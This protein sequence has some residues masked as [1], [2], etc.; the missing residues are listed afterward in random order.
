M[1]VSEERAALLDKL[2]DDHLRHEFAPPD[3]S[4]KLTMATMVKEPYVNHVP[5]LVG[6][7]G[8]VSLAHFYQHHFIFTNPAMSLSPVSRTIGA[9][10]IVDEMVVEFNHTSYVDW[11]VPGVAPTGR[12][13]RFPLV[14]IVCVQDEDG[15]P[16]VSHEHIYWD[17]ATILKQLG[18]ADFEGL[19]VTG[20]EQAAKVLDPR[21]VRSNALL[22]RT[23]RYAAPGAVPSGDL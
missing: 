7:V 3:K 8:K 10:Q 2:W 18:V 20:R 22:V 14:A 19:D 4:T 11:L 1:G 17:Q 13:V 9:T 16:K 5:T 23:G 15:V 21:A 6:G 12:N